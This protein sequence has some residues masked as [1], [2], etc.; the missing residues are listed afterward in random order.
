M[1]DEQT[2]YAQVINNLYGN[3]FDD[4]FYQAIVRMEVNTNYLPQLGTNY[5]DLKDQAELVIAKVK[6]EIKQLA[7]QYLLVSLNG[8]QVE[9]TELSSP[10]NRMFEIN[11]QVRLTEGE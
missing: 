3:L 1:I 5:F 9:F 2:N 10:W 11:C 7:K 8:K 6:N 4:T